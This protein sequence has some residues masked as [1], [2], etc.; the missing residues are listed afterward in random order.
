MVCGLS[1]VS[2]TGVTQPGLDVSSKFLKLMVPVNLGSRAAGLED[3][4]VDVLSSP[5]G[6]GVSHFCHGQTEVRWNRSIYVAACY[7]VW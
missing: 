6:F 1:A 3:F 4:M 7:C 2:G 5:K